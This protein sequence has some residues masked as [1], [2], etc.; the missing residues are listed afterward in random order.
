MAQLSDDCF[1]FGGPMMSVDEAVGLIAER[2]TPV[3]DVETVTLAGAAP[4]REANHFH[5]V[6]RTLRRN[7]AGL[8][9]QVLYIGWEIKSC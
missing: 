3:V 7:R 5:T 9:L 1:A 6:L 8:S 2:V 4:P